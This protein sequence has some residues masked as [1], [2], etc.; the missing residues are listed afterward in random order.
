MMHRSLYSAGKNYNKPDTMIMHNRLVPVMDDLDI[1]FVLA[2]HDHTYFRTKQMKG[3]QAQET[4]YFR[5]Y[6]TARRSPLPIIRRRQPISGG[7]QRRDGR[8]CR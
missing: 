6:T 1:D 7:I 4:T 2:G 3:D 8:L 5:R